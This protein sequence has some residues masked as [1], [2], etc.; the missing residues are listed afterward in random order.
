[1]GNFTNLIS[2]GDMESESDRPVCRVED[3]RMDPVEKRV[4]GALMEKEATTP[5]YCPLSLNALVNACNQKNN[6]RP[7]TAHPEADVSAALARLREKRLVASVT[8]GEHRVPKYRQTFA[9]T[10]RLDGPERAALCA[11]ML[12]GALTTGEVRG[13][14]SSM[15][16]F[17]DLAGVEDTLAAL[18]GRDG[19]PMVKRL[20]RRPGQKE[21]RWADV[22]CGD[23]PED[24]QDEPAAVGLPAPSRSASRAT[25]DEEYVS[26]LLSDTYKDKLSEL[27]ADVAQLRREL[28]ELA[29]EFRTFRAQFE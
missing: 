29:R 4:L 17:G 19:G 7:V 24:S 6:R 16:D 12:R 21:N 25:A 23:P 8:G 22:L 1:M 13:C 20:S 10:F 5:E 27:E 14:A 15:H 3:F 2:W 28:G 11:L 26:P 9:R 18:S